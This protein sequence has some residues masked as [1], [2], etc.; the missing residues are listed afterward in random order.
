MVTCYCSLN[1]QGLFPKSIHNDRK[2][3]PNFFPAITLWG[4][5]VIH[6]PLEL[7]MSQ[8]Y[9]M[10]LAEVGKC[11]PDREIVLLIPPYVHIVSPVSSY[12]NCCIKPIFV[13]VWNANSYCSIKGPNGIITSTSLSF[14]SDTHT[15]TY[16]QSLK[17]KP[18]ITLCKLCLLK[19]AHQA[20]WNTSE[21]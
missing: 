15:H 9:V 6:C 5:K 7:W 4:V 11:H 10:L 12:L 8:S 18:L 20:C 3:T 21:S 16:T 2:L 19:L 1:W 13:Q 17:T 14:H